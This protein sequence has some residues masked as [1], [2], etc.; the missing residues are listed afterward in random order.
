MCL[1]WSAQHSGILA[2]NQGHEVLQSYQN[3]VFAYM[4]YGCRMWNFL[5]ILKHFAYCSV[6][7]WSLMIWQDLF[8]VW[9]Q[10]AVQAQITQQYLGTCG[11]KAQPLTPPSKFPCSYSARPSFV[12]AFLLFLP[13]NTTVFLSGRWWP[14]KIS[15]YMFSYLF[16][17]LFVSVFFSLCCWRNSVSQGGWLSGWLAVEYLVPQKY[18]RLGIW[19]LRSVTA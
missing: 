11:S 2:W 4:P 6:I 12:L 19:L 8:W 10:L 15:I 18:N 13:P 7:P 14:W 16:V 9:F 5:H 17:C 3:G 1:C